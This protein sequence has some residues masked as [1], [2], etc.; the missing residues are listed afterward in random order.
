LPAADGSAELPVLRGST[1]E[2]PS[3][4]SAQ[5][6]VGV[7]QADSRPQATEQ[8]YA[9]VSR[10]FKAE[11]TAQAKDWESY[12]VVESR[13][14]TST[15]RRLTLDNVTRVTTDKVLENVQVLDTWFDQKTRQYY[16]LAG[17]NRAQ[18]EAAMVERLNELDRTIQTEVTEAHQT[19]D[20]LSR[21][22]NLKR[23]AKNLVLREAYNTDLRVLRSNG[24]GNASTYRVAEL[25]AELEQFLA[26]N[27]VMA[28]D[29]SG[30]QAEPLERAL[31]DGLAQEGFTVVGRGAG[32]VPAE[33]LISG[34]GASLADRS[35][36]SP[37]PLCPLVR[38]IRD[39][40]GRDPSCGR[41]PVER[42]EG[43]ACHGARGSR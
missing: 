29:L 41:G 1:E 17:M 14:Q 12:L 11:I 9:A 10:I 25:T 23:A 13:G 24:Q 37:L 43:R 2:A 32:A 39:R 21:V 28:V 26:K 8:A 38:G 16:A 6:L 18:A 20:K 36:R 31:V 34:V 5:Y 40:R 27:L 15:E 30:D 4:P 7:G 19:Q 42:R 3:F 35:E 22:R 33:L